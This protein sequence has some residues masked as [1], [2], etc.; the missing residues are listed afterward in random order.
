MPDPDVFNLPSVSAIESLLEDAV[1]KLNVCS[2]SG[3]D[4]I[5][6]H[7]INHASIL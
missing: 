3:F 7:Y 5:A 4:F 2:S 6:A 1:K